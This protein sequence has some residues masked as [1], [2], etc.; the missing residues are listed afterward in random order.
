[1]IE[2][3]I[4]R[5]ERP[6]ELK[7]YH[8]GAILYGDWGTSRFYVLG[9]AFFYSL[10]DSFWYVLGVGILVA[11]VGWAYTVVCRSFPDGGGVYSS[12]KRISQ[13]LAVVGAL[14]LCADYIVTAALS[15][16]DG[17]QY[18]HLPDEGLLIPLLSMAVIFIIGV[19]NYFG[20]RRVSVLALWVAMATLVLTL[21]VAAFSIPHLAQGWH[22]IAPIS[23]LSGD[24]RHKWF[25]FVSVVLALSGVEAVANMT[26]VMVP[27]VARTS[28]RTI[29]PVLLEVV[30]LNL[31]LAVGM[32]A[33]SPNP[34]RPHERFTTPAVK[35]QAGAA[36]YEAAHKHWRDRPAEA[37]EVRSLDPLRHRENRIQNAVVGV[38]ATDFVSRP[39]GWLCGL[40]FGLLLISAVNTAIGAMMSVQYTMA[41]DGEL[42]RFLTRLNA[43]G[44]PWLALIPAVTVPILILALFHDLATLGDLYAIGVVGAITISLASTA[45]N[46][47]LAV[48]LW[49][50][51]SLGAIALIMLAIEL[52]LIVEK[53]EARI[54]AG[55]VLGVGLLA[56][57]Y[58]RQFPALPL[59]K[60]FV[61]LGASAG[62]AFLSSAYLLYLGRLSWAESEAIGAIWL[63]GGSALCFG[64]ALVAGYY[65]NSLRLHLAKVA[66][67]VPAEVAALPES[68][69]PAELIDMDRPGVLVATRGAPRLLEFAANYAAQVKGNLFVLF[70]RQ[71]NLAFVPE[72]EGPS[73][74]EDVE[75][76]S[77]FATAAKYCREKKVP[78]MPI[79]VV[80]PDVAYSILDFAGTYGVSALL[81]GVSRRAGL[82]RVLQ[83]DTL[84][85][86]ADQLPQDIPLLIHA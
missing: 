82:L 63:W 81:M 11:M 3:P 79:Y 30:I 27:P 38:M 35:T 10:Y 28:R 57:F 64:L 40:V 47:E 56:R 61:V 14:L 72:G 59:R 12:A 52:T 29:W 33:L 58:T 20:L 25:N 65:F 45:F 67:A 13:Q 21:V 85:Q 18:L 15:A 51:A 16:F 4:T 39:F 73:L 6:R 77:T 36:S 41:R 48:K 43:F 76:L 83:G 32:N 5:R 22:R 55:C 1:M 62:V 69:R 54:F 37:A 71:F 80:S 31:I 7:W 78:M 68:A 46:R 44:V 50:R 74:D 19:M 42:P 66:E 26:G 2:S 17:L 24:I 60:Q 70:V 75:A 8:A 86:V 49:E 23:S 9:L 34:A 53:P 84:S